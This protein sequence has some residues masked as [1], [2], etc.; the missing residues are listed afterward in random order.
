MSLAQ[1]AM[2][3]E[4]HRLPVFPAGARWFS[5]DMNA[6]DEDQRERL[7]LL[8]SYKLASVL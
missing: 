4:L 8:R 1:L 3:R 7:I 6:I 5:A 2:W